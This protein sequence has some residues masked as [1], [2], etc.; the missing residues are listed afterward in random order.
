MGKLMWACFVATGA[1]ALAVACGT[2][3]QNND[4]DPNAVTG[5]SAPANWSG[6]KAKWTRVDP[7]DGSCPEV[8]FK[9]DADGNF[10]SQGCGGEVA[11]KLTAYE[12]NHLNQAANA[13]VPELTESAACDLQRNPDLKVELVLTSP[14][15]ND[16]KFMYT[17]RGGNTCRQGEVPDVT[18]LAQVLLEIQLKYEAGLPKPPPTPTPTP[19]PVPAPIPLPDHPIPI[20]TATPDN[21]LPFPFPHF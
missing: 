15:G 10:L 16:H 4:I 7:W 13:V 14:D 3:N 18:A 11:G 17:D 12:I 21:P 1:M 20:P 5:R 9:S 19:T 2:K 6:V 8:N